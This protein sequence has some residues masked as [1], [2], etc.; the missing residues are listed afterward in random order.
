MALTLA[1]ALPDNGSPNVRITRTPARFSRTDKTTF[2]PAGMRVVLAIPQ[3]N[4]A[5]SVD[6]GPEFAIFVGAAFIA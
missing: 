5:H 6:F 3:T 2:A 4:Q 1:P